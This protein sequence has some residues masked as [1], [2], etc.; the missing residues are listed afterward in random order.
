MGKEKN[1]YSKIAVVLIAFIFMVGCSTLKNVVGIGNSADTEPASTGAFIV[2]AQTQGITETANNI[3]RSQAVVS[4]GVQKTYGIGN[5]K[6]SRTISF[7]IGNSGDEAI[8]NISITSSSN[9]L[10]FTPSTF[11]VLDGGD[12][13]NFELFDIGIEHGVAINGIGYVDILTMGEHLPTFNVTGTTEGGD[14]ISS[15]YQLTFNAKVAA[16]ELI[17]GGT[18]K[19]ISVGDS[20]GTSPYGNLNNAKYFY[21]NNQSIEIRNIGNVDLNVRLLGHFDNINSLYSTYTIPQ[22]QT[23]TINTPLT[24]YNQ[25]VEVG[26]SNTVF[27]FDLYDVGTNGRAYLE[28]L[29][30]ASP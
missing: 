19:D 4:N 29:D 22:S 8:N 24:P 6:A 27:N 25:W 2:R 7:L 14:T 9:Y 5:L 3:A 21:S 10:A 30:A 26:G 15:T 20:N 18:T 28:L 11:Q 16:F 12:S 13:A 23:V 17:V 1:N